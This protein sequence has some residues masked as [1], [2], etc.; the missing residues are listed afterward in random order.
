MRVY[1]RAGS[2]FW[3]VEISTVSGKVRFSSGTDIKREA[4]KL[5]TYRQQAAND[6][7]HYG[8]ARSATLADACKAYLDDQKQKAAGT[9]AVALFNV[10]HLSDGAVWPP[11]TPFETLTSAQLFRLQKLKSK[12][13]GINSVNHITTALTTMRNRCEVWE[14]LAP[15]FKVAKFKPKAKF[16]YLQ[17]GEEAELLGVMKDQ[18]TID[19]TMFLLDTGM[20]VG[21]LVALMWSDISTENGLQYLVTYRSKTDVRTLLPITKRL[22][23]ALR[24]RKEASSSL[25]VFPHKTK[26][27]H[28]RTTAAKSI[29]K[30]ADRAGLNPPEIVSKLGKFT[31]H[32]CRDTYA[33]RLVKGGMTLYQVQILLGHASP[34]MTQKYA[35]L[36]TADIGHLVL[37]AIDH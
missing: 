13:L 2:G 17:E 32:S 10:R 26:V 19:L 6:T 23:E 4:V 25:Y 29:A 11:S 16:R 3:Q 1:R 27:G 8:A 5:A 12:E 21:E 18:D 28:H 22:T 34:I 31:A 35:H 37:K 7:K 14:F 30:A 24:R 15:T 20:R 36:T 9:Y 33:T